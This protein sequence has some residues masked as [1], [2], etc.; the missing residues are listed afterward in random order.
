VKE[1]ADYMGQEYTHGG[2]LMYMIENLTNYNFIR[3]KD[4]PGGANQYEIESWKKQL[5]LFWKGQDNLQTIVQH[6]SEQT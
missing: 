5:D 6:Y 1:I 4:S 2:N 3:P